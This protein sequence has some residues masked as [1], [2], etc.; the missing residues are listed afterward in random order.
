MLLS[1]PVFA[2][3][4]GQEVSCEVHHGDVDRSG[5][6]SSEVLRAETPQSD[7]G[8]LV[9]RAQPRLITAD[10]SRAQTARTHTYGK[11][12]VA[13]PRVYFITSYQ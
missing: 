13:T 9:T 5:G 2:D 12:R 3:D 11:A 6:S 4:I 1:V 10:V 8:V 7:G